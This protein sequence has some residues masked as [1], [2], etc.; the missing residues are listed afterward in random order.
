[1]VYPSGMTERLYPKNGE[2]KRRIGK[3]KLGLFPDACELKQKKP[4]PV[5]I[6]AKY[7]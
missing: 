5:K 4:Q 2:K 7:L 3:E 1:M 6:T